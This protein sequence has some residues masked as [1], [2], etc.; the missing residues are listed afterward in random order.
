MVPSAA[1]A[2][3]YREKS[4]FDAGRALTLSI[5]ED[6]GKIDKLFPARNRPP[7]CCDQPRLENRAAGIARSTMRN[8]LRRYQD[9]FPA[10][11]QMRAARHRAGANRHRRGRAANAFPEV[12]VAPLARVRDAPA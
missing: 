5:K 2:N 11:V 12:A 1:A 8:A 7:A 10:R 9:R 4:M 6:R 3:A